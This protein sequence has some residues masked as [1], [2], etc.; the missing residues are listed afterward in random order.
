MRAPFPFQPG[1]E[2]LQSFPPGQDSIKMLPPNSADSHSA[3]K[4]TPPVPLTIHFSIM[5]IWQFLKKILFIQLVEQCSHSVQGHHIIIWHLASRRPKHQGFS[6]QEHNSQS[7]PRKE[8]PP[9]K[10][11]FFWAL[12]EREGALF[13]FRRRGEYFYFC[14][15]PGSNKKKFS[16]SY[17]QI[18]VF[19]AEILVRNSYV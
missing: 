2:V 10:I 9:W 16:C 5:M 15:S 3:R 17:I 18:R 13:V 11:V 8:R 1:A 12:P 6:A 19:C 7:L 14:R 4:W